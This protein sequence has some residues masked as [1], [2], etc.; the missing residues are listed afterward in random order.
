MDSFPLE[1]EYDKVHELGGG[2]YGTVW[3]WKRKRKLKIEDN[4]PRYVAVKSV[5]HT[6]DVRHAKTR[7]RE[8]NILKAVQQSSCL[9]IVDYYGSF[10][11][12]SV[13]TDQTALVMEACHGDLRSLM[14]SQR[15]LEEDELRH[16]GKQILNGLHHLHGSDGSAR[17]LHRFCFWL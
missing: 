11:D 9:N 3:L 1:E 8:Q 16:L 2:S 4:K 12:S 6:S 13:T 17:I 15:N 10:H 5:V 14:V 7:Q